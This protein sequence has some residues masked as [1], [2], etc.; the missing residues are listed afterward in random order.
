MST[1]SSNHRLAVLLILAATANFAHAGS[2]WDDEETSEPAIQLVSGVRSDRAAYLTDIADDPPEDDEL[3]EYLTGIDDEKGGKSKGKGTEKANKD[4]KKP[5]SVEDRLKDLSEEN[6]KLTKKLDD[7]VKAFKE[8][9]DAKP[10]PKYPTAELHGFVNLSTGWFNQDQDN[11]AAVGNLRDGSSFRRAR[12]AASGNILENM[13]YVVQMDFGGIGRP[14]F[15]DVWTEFNKVPLFGNVRVGHWKQPFSLEVVSPSKF[16]TFSERSLLFQAFTP[17][18]HIA[19]GMQDNAENELSTWAASIYRSGQDQYGGSI[20]DKGGYAGVGRYTFL[21]YWDEESKG[22]RYVHLGGAYNYV[23]PNNSLVQFRTL[24]SFFVGSQAS[25][26][27]PGS[28]GTSGQGLPGPLNGTP[29]FADTKAFGMNHYHLVG[30]EALWV[31]GP[32]SVQAEGMILAGTRTGGGH[33][34]FPGVY[35]QA[36]YFLTGEHRPY[37]R[38]SG[39]IDRIKVKNPIGGGE[40]EGYGSGAW[41]LAT[42]WDYIDL[43]SGGVQGGQQE[44]ITIGINWFFNDYTKLQANYIRANLSRNVASVANLYTL[45]LQWEF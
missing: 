35:A 44:D 21:P 18:R 19:L 5:K 28:T 2:W 38:K 22:E 8:F 23:S 31:E 41:E 12:L 39:T 13:K 1:K 40:K 33:I 15:T 34:Y 3:D 27:A 6:K 9:K 37:N 11:I 20:T 32:F 36:G 16:T 43:N 7:Q 14:T 30:T 4:D 17:Q 26:P 24:P 25:L 10:K 42:R 29:F 45:Q